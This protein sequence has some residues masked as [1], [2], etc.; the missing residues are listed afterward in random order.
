MSNQ[1]SP[2]NEA[3]LKSLKNLTTN[4]TKEQ[5]IWLNGYIQGF[6][7]STFAS[8]DS[9]TSPATI[10]RRVATPLTILYGT[11]TGRSEKIA[12]E[13]HT[14]ATAKNF[15]ST[16]LAMNQ[17][18]PR[19]LKDEK[20]LLIIVSTHGEGEPPVM[21]NDFHEFITGKRAPN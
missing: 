6:T 15:E 16:L 20:N 18:K 10:E 7:A 1:L 9:E 2:L 8:A 5:A 19:N 4:L 17:Y 12:S 3:Q 21:A 14:E 13:I 11:H